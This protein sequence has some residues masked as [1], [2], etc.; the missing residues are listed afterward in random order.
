[1]SAGGENE[2][3]TEEVDRAGL[4]RI[5]KRAAYI[6]ISLALL[7]AIVSGINQLCACVGTYLIL[8]DHYSYQIIPMPL[9]GSNYVFSRKFFTAWISVAIGWLLVAGSLCMYVDS[10]DPVSVIALTRY[11]AVSFPSGNL[12]LRYI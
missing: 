1:M 5:F 3:D 9:F 4:Q 12:A 6:S 10:K 8:T 2:S 7:I 11:L